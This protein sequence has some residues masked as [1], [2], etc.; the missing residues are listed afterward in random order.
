MANTDVIDMYGIYDNPKDAPG[1]FIVRRWEVRAGK[2]EGKERV[3]WDTLEEA[4]KSVS[5]GRTAIPR[6]PSDDPCIVETWM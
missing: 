1:K 5:N 2:V 4:R 3:I 6:Q